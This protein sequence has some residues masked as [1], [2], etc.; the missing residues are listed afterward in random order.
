MSLFRLRNRRCCS[1]VLLLTF[2]LY[3]SSQ[4][5]DS[6]QWEPSPS[7]THPV[8]PGL[9]L[10]QGAG[11]RSGDMEVHRQGDLLLGV[12]HLVT[13]RGSGTQVSIIARAIPSHW[14]VSELITRATTPT[15]L[16]RAT[17]MDPS[18]TCLKEGLGHPG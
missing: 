10:V 13:S 16:C 4:P 12:S 9:Q 18:D 8:S 1:G 7:S 3:H 15:G 6:V 17:K 14:P 11:R 2:D 5:L